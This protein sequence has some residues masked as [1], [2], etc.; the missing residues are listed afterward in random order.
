VAAVPQLL[1]ESSGRTVA[2][3]QTVPSPVTA[4]VRLVGE[5][6][7]TRIE[8]SCSYGKPASGSSATRVY[9]L[10]VTDRTGQTVRLATWVAEP[11]VE[12][13][14]YAT[15]T[16]AAADIARIDIR[17]EQSGRVLLK[18]DL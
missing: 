5:P 13:E 3:V 2:L 14:P 16:L 1:E 12:A 10:Y 7:G 15:T 9:G 18:V 17:S 4:N 8:A 11:G 6:W